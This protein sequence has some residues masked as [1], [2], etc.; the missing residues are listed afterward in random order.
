[1][2]KHTVFGDL[3]IRSQR[4]EKQGVVCFVS[5]KTWNKVH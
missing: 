2:K 4:G 5:D 1:M 3:L